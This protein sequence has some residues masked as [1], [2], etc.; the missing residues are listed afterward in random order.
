MP[1]KNGSMRYIK[2][3]SGTYFLL[4]HYLDASD[5]NKY[6]KKYF[7]SIESLSKFGIEDIIFFILFFFSYKIKPSGIFLSYIIPI[8]NSQSRVRL[9]LNSIFYYSCFQ[10]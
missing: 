7:E 8:A 2:L 10:N 5:P 3:P 9:P 6:K 4:G 1:F